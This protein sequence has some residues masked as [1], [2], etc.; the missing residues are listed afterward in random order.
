M[1]GYLTHLPLCDNKAA[2]VYPNVARFL[3]SN[4]GN[5][6]QRVSLYLRQ[7]FKDCVSNQYTF[8]DMLNWKR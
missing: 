8:F 3:I 5:P 7:N 1:S 2:V 4:T 6:A